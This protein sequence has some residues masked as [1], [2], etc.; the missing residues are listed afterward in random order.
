MTVRV[1]LELVEQLSQAWVLDGVSGSAL[2]QEEIPE[3]MEPVVTQ[4][5][6]LRQATGVTKSFM[7]LELNVTYLQGIGVQKCAEQDT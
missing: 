3:T 4:D 6:L 5:I 2:K 1:H 7:L